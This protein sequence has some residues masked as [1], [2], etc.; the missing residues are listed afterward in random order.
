M[1]WK[2]IESA[3]K[4]RRILVF[5]RGGGIWIAA[6]GN[7]YSPF[8]RGEVQGWWTSSDPE[9]SHVVRKDDATHWMP[10]PSPPGGSE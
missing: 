6:W 1:E 8:Y 10:L 9:R 7:Y 5:E 4:D 3:P 2:P